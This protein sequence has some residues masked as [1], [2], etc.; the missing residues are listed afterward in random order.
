MTKP[1]KNVYSIENGELIK[2]TENKIEYTD[3]KGVKRVKTNPSYSDFLKVGK[4][5]LK[6]DDLIENTTQGEVF[7][8]IS[9]EYIVKRVKE[10]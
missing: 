2:N 5:R 4:Y 9:G 3:E 6:E 7:Y 8:E 1:Y 10:G